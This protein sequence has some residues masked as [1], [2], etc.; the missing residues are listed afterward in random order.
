MNHQKRSQKRNFNRCAVRL[1]HLA[2]F[3]LCLWSSLVLSGCIAGKLAGA[4][5]AAQEAQKLN[6][7]LPRYTG[8]E[9]HTVAV[10]VEADY[11]T[12][13]ERPSLVQTVASGV[14]FR[15]AKW[16]PNVQVLDPTVVL[17]WQF[18]KPQWNTLPYGEIA[19]QLNVDRVVFV[20]ILEYRLN[21]P[22]NQWL[23]EGV[24]VA[25]VGIVERG[26][27]DPDSFSDTFD[28]SAEYPAV[29]GV[30]RENA[31]QVQIETGLLYEFVKRTGW[32]FHLH[33]EPKHPTQYRPELD[34]DEMKE[35]KRATGS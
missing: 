5:G 17:N 34:T 6:E 7:V 22:G 25:R 4:M 20:E 11:V 1:R 29:S 14:T 35:V 2:T 28:I 33:Y 21:P 24:A 8:L 31:A 18:T 10:V 26:G 19:A 9:N 32:L 27:L 23:W 3:A 16:V 12:T 30:T 13:F 15:I